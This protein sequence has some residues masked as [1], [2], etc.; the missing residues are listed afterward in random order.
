MESEE[1][2]IERKNRNKKESYI[3]NIT[4]KKCRK[5]RRANGSSRCGQCSSLHI[6]QK[7]ND[8]RLERK[9]IEQTEIKK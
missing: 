4:C 9:M 2:R 8:A 3:R 1:Q 6:A 7:A 5:N